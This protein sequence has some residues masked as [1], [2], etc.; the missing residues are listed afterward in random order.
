MS[1]VTTTTPS[2][3]PT[4]SDVWF[5]AAAVLGSR[6]GTLAKMIA[7]RTVVATTKPA[8]M[9]MNGTMKYR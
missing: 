1:V 9:A 8:P 4:S 6:R 2:W 3:L 5:R 7:V